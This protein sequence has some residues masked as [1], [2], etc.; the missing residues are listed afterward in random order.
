VIITKRQQSNLV[1]KLH[2]VK[3]HLFIRSIDL[4]PMNGTLFR[5]IEDTVL[6]VRPLLRKSEKPNSFDVRIDDNEWLC[7]ACSFVGPTRQDDSFVMVVPKYGVPTPRLPYVIRERGDNTVEIAFS[8]EFMEKLAH[9]VWDT[10]DKGQ[11]RAA[12]W[13]WPLPGA[14]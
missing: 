10:A 7:Y 8:Q 3:E 12:A 4:E 5:I 9:A 1:L 6:Y 2:Y 14:Q 13:I 11:P